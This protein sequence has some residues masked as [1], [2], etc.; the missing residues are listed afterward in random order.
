MELIRVNMEDYNAVA[1]S[2]HYVAKRVDIPAHFLTPKEIL[3]VEDGDELFGVIVLYNFKI[4]SLGNHEV[5]LTFAADSSKAWTRKI[6]VE[7]FDFVFGFMQCIRA[8]SGCA[9]DNTKSQDYLDRLGFTFEGRSQKGWDGV[10]DKMW[11]G[12]TKNNCKWLEIE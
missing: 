1:H 3:R 10:K 12:M 9:A 11:Y 6:I 7:T 8:A 2:L 4:L 5:E